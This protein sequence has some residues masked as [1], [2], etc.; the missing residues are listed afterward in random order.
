MP[1]GQPPYHA[2]NPPERIRWPTRSL[3][4]AAVSAATADINAPTLGGTP[5][6]MNNNHRDQADH[7]EDS[8]I[9]VQIIPP[10]QVPGGS[11]VVEKPTEKVRAMATSSTTAP[12]VSS[13]L[14]PIKDA[15]SEGEKVSTESANDDASVSSSDSSC[16]GSSGN[17]SS[18]S[19]SGQS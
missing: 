14:V 7:V 11:Q 1:R 16:R 10:V 12:A 9:A 13:S 17:S 3:S 2:S 8:L 6:P 5:L 15:K 19:S 4:A 18:T